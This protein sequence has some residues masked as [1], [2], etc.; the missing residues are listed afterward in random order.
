MN[1]E[2]LY[3]SVGSFMGFFRKRGGGRGGGTNF[4]IFMAALSRCQKFLSPA[5]ICKV[6]YMIVLDKG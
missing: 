1:C 5:T 2:I 6:N 3:T 4:P